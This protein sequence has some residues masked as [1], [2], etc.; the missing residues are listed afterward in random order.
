MPVSDRHVDKLVE[1]V[2]GQDCLESP[3]G[4]FDGAVPEC[5]ELPGGVVGGGGERPP[6][7]VSHSAVFHGAPNGCPL[8]LAVKM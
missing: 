6:V 7:R 8:S 2:V 3:S 4:P 1:P 5:V